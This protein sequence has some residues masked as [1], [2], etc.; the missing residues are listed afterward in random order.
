MTLQEEIGIM[1]TIGWMNT[2]KISHPLKKNFILPGKHTG[3]CYAARCMPTSALTTEWASYCY[4]KTESIFSDM[5]RRQYEDIVYA[6]YKLVRSSLSKKA[7]QT[8]LLKCLRRSGCFP[9]PCGYVAHRTGLYSLHPARAG[10][11]ERAG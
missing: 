8:I 11:G 4:L 6:S 10:G 3:I 1:K 2:C 7:Q 9:P 5:L